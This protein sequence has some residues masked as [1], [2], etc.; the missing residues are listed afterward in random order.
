VNALRPDEARNGRRLLHAIISMGTGGA[1]RQLAYLAGELVSSGWDVH[2]ALRSGGENLRR[3]AASGATVHFI[4]AAS[5]YDPRLVLRYHRLIKRLQ[6]SLVQTW[7]TQSDVFCGTAALSAGVPW[8]LSE[9]SA[10]AAYPP[11]WRNRLRAHLGRRAS[12]IVANSQGGADYW[13]TVVGERVPRFVIPN[14]LPLDA[15]DAV[16]PVPRTLLPGGS[17]P[18]LLYV[19]RLYQQEKN[20]FGLALAL[21][22]VVEETGAHLL[23]CGDGPD[24]SA[25]G[26]LLSGA[27]LADHVHFLGVRDDVWALMKSVDLLVSTS[28]FEGHPNGVLEAVAVGCPVV[29]S[30]IPAHRAILDPACAVF[31]DPGNAAAIA[32][33]IVR[34]L[35]RPAESRARA[36][37]AQPRVRELSVAAMRARYEQ[38]YCRLLPQGGR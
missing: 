29:I 38:V 22:R 9:R 6:P 11:T 36:A 37:M 15:M 24:A 21:R 23:V 2:V 26:Q 10:A 28:F 13:R 16:A 20:V 35:E 12:A 4:H 5:N 31:V 18:L 17:A 27:G 1:E 30:D 25:V 8:I 3:L 14:G 34:A 32:E 19:G 33:G 7:I